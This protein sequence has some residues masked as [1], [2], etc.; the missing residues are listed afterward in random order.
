MK[1]GWQGGWQ[2]GLAGGGTQGREPAF[3]AG[4]TR[5][6]IQ[7][8]AFL[9]DQGGATPRICMHLF[10]LSSCHVVYWATTQPC[11][12]SICRARHGRDMDEMWMR[13]G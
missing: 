10:C 6:C 5:A 2:G 4:R 11:S 12:P 7:V 13:Y 8:L 1:R 9:L 3:C